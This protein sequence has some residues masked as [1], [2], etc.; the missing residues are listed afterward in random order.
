MQLSTGLNETLWE[1]RAMLSIDATA[2]QS[3]SHT[4]LKA[5]ETYFANPQNVKKF[6]EWQLTH[7][8]EEKKSNG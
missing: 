7:K 6:E 1:V 8:K 5:V 4:F 3:L 2:K